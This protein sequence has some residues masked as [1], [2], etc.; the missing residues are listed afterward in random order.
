MKGR[1]IGLG[2][3]V[4]ALAI[5]AGVVTGAQAGQVPA[6]AACAQMECEMGIFCQ[7]NSGGGTFC[8]R[9][10]NSNVCKTMACEPE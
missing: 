2:F 1:F 3:A 7:D 5:G 8:K 10:D 4:L 9:E 6:R